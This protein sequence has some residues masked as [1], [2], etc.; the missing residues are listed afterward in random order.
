MVKVLFLDIDG[1][2]HPAAE[3]GDVFLP[4]PCLQSWGLEMHGCMRRVL[5]EPQG[6]IRVCRVQERFHQSEEVLLP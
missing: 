1:V 2:L 3:H 4:V 6:P 5:N